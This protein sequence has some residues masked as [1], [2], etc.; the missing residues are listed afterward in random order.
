MS[1]DNDTEVNVHCFKLSKYQQADLFVRVE[2]IEDPDIPLRDVNLLH[3][4]SLHTS[5]HMYSFDY[6]R[7]APSVTFHPGVST[8]NVTTYCTGGMTV[9]R[10]VLNKGAKALLLDGRHHLEAMRLL[11]A[12]GDVG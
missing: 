10:T 9:V 4:T 1:V 2:Q 5:F 6:S 3:V 11:H 12:E 8:G 7:G